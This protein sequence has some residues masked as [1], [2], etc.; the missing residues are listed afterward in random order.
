MG[1]EKNHQGVGLR[2]NRKFILFH[3]HVFYILH[4]LKESYFTYIVKEA[5]IFVGKIMLYLAF[6]SEAVWVFGF[7]VS[8][9]VPSSKAASRW[10]HST[11]KKIAWP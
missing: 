11:S 5:I 2:S 4:F 1:K 3:I 8:E 6:T 9:R 7:V 10:Q